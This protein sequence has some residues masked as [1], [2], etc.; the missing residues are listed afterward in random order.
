MNNNNNKSQIILTINFKKM[1]IIIFHI[2]F[3]YF[4]IIKNIFISK[5]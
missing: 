5:D 2:L 3:L 4:Y 1:N